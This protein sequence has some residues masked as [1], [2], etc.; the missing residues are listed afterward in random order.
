ME[1]LLSKKQVIYLYLGECNLIDMFDMLREVAS[2][3]KPA[4]GS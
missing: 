2:P 3:F 1:I 4:L